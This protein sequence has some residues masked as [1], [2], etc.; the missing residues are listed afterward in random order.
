MKELKRVH[1]LDEL[2]AENKRLRRM[3]LTDE[4]TG[5]YNFRHLVKQ[6]DIEVEESKRSNAPLSVIM[7]DIDHFKK[8][9]DDHGHVVGNT[10]LKQF[11]NVLS[12]SVRSHDIV[13]RFGGEEFVII[14]PNTAMNVAS[15]IAERTRLA[16][17]KG[18][19]G[20]YKASVIMTCSFGVTDLQS[21]DEDTLI[22]DNPSDYSS[23][24]LQKADHNLYQAKAAG[25]NQVFSD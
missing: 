10:I 20:N 3:L 9:N 4:L 12:K 6:I 24:L 8:T 5:V 11:S 18:I 25:R 23:K 13:C 15:E 22:R 14:L 19:Y 17:E 2:I 16:V 21:I 7:A 1:T